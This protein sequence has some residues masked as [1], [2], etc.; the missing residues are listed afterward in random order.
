M[1]VLLLIAAIASYAAWVVGLFVTSQ[2]AAQDY[3]AH[4]AKVR[5]SLSKIYLGCEALKK[6]IAI[7][8]SG[9]LHASQALA[10]LVVTVQLMVEL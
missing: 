10:Q 9:F 3:Q 7:P 4:S 6:Q 1:Q 5:T 8:W 2:G